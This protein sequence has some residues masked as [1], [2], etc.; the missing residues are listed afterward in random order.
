MQNLPRAH[1]P[2]G[3]HRPA[4]PPEGGPATA[5]RGPEEPPGPPLL[6]VDVGGVVIDRIADGTDT[7]FFGDDPMSTP[8]V[9]GV[10]TALAALTEAFDGRVRVISKAGPRTA[11]RTRDWL[12]VHRFAERT[13]VPPENLHFVRERPDKAPVAARL[14]VTHFV[15]DLLDVLVHLDTVPHRYLFTGGLGKEEPPSEVPGWAVRA[16]TWPELTGLI[17]ATLPPRG[18]G[19]AGGAP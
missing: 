1:G 13:G 9:P 4:A 17:L 14:G 16:D 7:S 11:Q 19:T 2:H 12:A 6:G 15:D 18:A 10:F 3:P 5:R 8:A